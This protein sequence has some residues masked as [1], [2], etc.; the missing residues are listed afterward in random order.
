MSELQKYVF[1][2]WMRQG[3]SRSINETDNLGESSSSEIERATLDVSLNWNTETTTKTA[4]LY[5]PGDITSL[6]EKAILRTEPANDSYDFEANYL[7][8]IEFYEE[9]FLW[10]YTPASPNAT[11]DKRLRSW[12][13]L[14]VMK[15]DEFEILSQS[16]PLPIVNIVGDMNAIFHPQK[17]HWAWAHVQFNPETAEDLV[18]VNT[19]INRIKQNPDSAFSRLMSTRKLERNTKYTAFLIPAFETGRL[20]GMGESLKD[21]G[22]TIDVPSQHPSWGD[23]T[24]FSFA[25]KRATEFPFYKQWR[26]TTSELGDFEYL[27]R[28]L[29]PKEMA[30]ELGARDLDITET[31]MGLN[32]SYSETVNLEGALMPPTYVPKP[33]PDSGGGNSDQ[34]YIDQ[35]MNILN[36][37]DSL[38][39]NSSPSISTN[40][41]YAAPIEDDPIITPPLYG[42]WHALKNRIDAGENTWFEELNIH[43]SYRSIAGLG[44]QVVKDKQEE[45]MERSWNQIGEIEAANQQLRQAEL[46]LL[47]SQ[48]MLDKNVNS[49]NEDKK[50]HI[51]GPM[52]KK[53][54]LAN[55]FTL[56][57][58]INDTVIPN[59]A[60]NSG[61]RK[62]YRNRSKIIKKSANAHNTG[63][64]SITESTLTNFNSNSSNAL[65]A[66]QEK[67]TPVLNVDY[68]GIGG[69][70]NSVGTTNPN[71]VGF[72][73][74]VSQYIHNLD[75]DTSMNLPPSPPL[76]N[77]QTELETK[78]SPDYTLLKKWG[79]KLK[80][81]NGSSF[82]AINQIKPIMAY[83]KFKDSMYL[84]LLKMNQEF[85]VP[86]LGQYPNNMVTLLET[87]RKFIESFMVG[88][89]HEMSRELLWREFPT[90]QRGSYFRQFW[91][92]KDHGDQLTEDEEI[93]IEK[94]H[95]WGNSSLGEN[96][97]TRLS[98]AS[99]TGGKIVLFVRGDLLRK[100]PNT[101]IY[102]QKAVNNPAVEDPDTGNFVIDKS[103]PRNLSAGSGDIK[104]PIFKA[105]LN[106]DVTILGFDLTEDEVRTNI[107]LDPSTGTF[108]ANDNP[109]WFFV[110][111][112]R[113]GQVRFGL[114]DLSDGLVIDSSSTWDD[115]AWE[116]L[117]EGT[118]PNHIELNL[119]SVATD[120]DTINTNTT[121]IDWGD[122]AAN[123]A[124]IL[125]QDPVMI[126]IHA[127]DMLP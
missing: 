56:K 45:Y 70:M 115:L 87:N 118:V 124:H 112:E 97:S 109:G 27:V 127:D 12:L 100:F 67:E 72:A 105:E 60:F 32:T 102:A 14:I 96:H 33:W 80:V 3:I 26:F 59:A 106:E 76:G 57:K 73:N 34:G 35:L 44:T 18:D 81:L 15:E 94:I 49:L 91:D 104:F 107:D 51:T 103:N 38:S 125:Y 17:E 69:A 4:K 61:F 117:G 47:V 40:P 13:A 78:I 39:E 28:L 77:I 2:P 21:D 65:V 36:L 93:D 46:S 88:I 101:L 113:P 24:G 30:P 42:Q 126:A 7:P 50:K 19:V 79:N 99:G 114:D 11:N 43:P 10:R 52:H 121:D 25:R 90:D 74:D 23:V 120:V 54:K 48:Q 9:D 92:I 1:L 37:Q 108:G 8:F 5:G 71:T 85:I 89:N 16:H 111:R 62:I 75:S 86:N 53:V 41:F 123:M 29:Q 63:V 64:N 82:N 20:G 55:G 119:D 110:F 116:H 68:T 58:E 122:N 66:A 83:P 95:E 6:S 84:E 98:Q 31:G 22:G